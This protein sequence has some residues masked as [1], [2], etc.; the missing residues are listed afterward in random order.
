MRHVQRF[1]I[2]ILA[3]ACLLAVGCYYDPVEVLGDK[4]A[5]DESA[6]AAA[7]P[8][9]GPRRIIPPR[10]RAA[11]ALQEAKAYRLLDE[12]FDSYEGGRYDAAI[13]ICTKLLAEKRD[14]AWGYCLRGCASHAKGDYSDAVR[15]QTAAI[16]C[17]AD[18]AEAY[19]YRALA[20]MEAGQ[21]AYAIADGTTAILLR[22]DFAEAH[23][24]RGLAYFKRGNYTKSLRDL[25]I[26][27]SLG[28]AVDP[29]LLALARKLAEAQEAEDY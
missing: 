15:D 27:A 26:A 8:S 20:Y 29:D 7:T 16:A 21:L 28:L 14:F 17:K 3:A 1:A 4:Q 18:L 9:G 11:D 23:Y 6:V 24:Y 12:A 13:R 19:C 22:A 2:L 5:G 10:P 25:R